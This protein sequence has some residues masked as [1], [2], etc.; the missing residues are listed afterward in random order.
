MRWQATLTVKRPAHE[1]WAF[2]TDNFNIPRLGGTTL[3]VRR[4]SPGP[5]G[6]GSTF[7]LRQM[8]A[9]F[10]TRFDGVITLWDPPRASEL[11]VTGPAVR[12]AIVRHTFEPTADGTRIV[13]TIEVE[14]RRLLRVVMPV[15]G[16]ILKHRW[17]AATKKLPTLLDETLRKGPRQDES[18]AMSASGLGVI[19]TVMFTDI[20]GS[21]ALV[22]AIGD[23]AWRD[24]RRW[25]DVQLRSAFVR[26]A[27]REIDHAG[28]GFFVTFETSAAAVNCA[29]EIQR[30]LL[31]HRRTAGFAP[32]VRIG[33]HSGEVTPD[34][35][36]FTGSAVHV[37]ARIAAVAESGQIL[38]TAAA[39]RDAGFV[40]AGP[41]THVQVA[42]VREP[43]AVVPLA[44]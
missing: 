32:A 20:V 7:H 4:T 14:P 8:I 2:M 44:W 26:H 17:D 34:G 42:G 25:H 39:V 24:L 23:S 12:A 27:G 5:T 15:L 36:T 37:A 35:A 40:P 19:R 29:I 31:E 16:P 43:I 41:Q 21:T 38:A 22:E 10:E 3:L 13:R 28:D 18:R 6:L 9:G 11:S 33:L 1:I 30:M